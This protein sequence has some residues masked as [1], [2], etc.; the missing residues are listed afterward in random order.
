M[1]F[2]VGASW[3]VFGPSEDRYVRSG[4]LLFVSVSLLFV[5]HFGVSAWHLKCAKLVGPNSSVVQ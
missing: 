5:P 2:E 4:V 3:I 1:R